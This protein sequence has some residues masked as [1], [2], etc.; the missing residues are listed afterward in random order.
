M[1]VWR[2]HPEV[3]K[4]L[5][6]KRTISWE[7]H[8]TFVALL[9]NSKKRFYWLARYRGEEC[10][11]V[12]LRIDPRDN[13]GEPGIFLAPEL[14]GSGIGTEIGFEAKHIYFEQ[15]GIDALHSVILKSNKPV[16]LTHEI[17]GYRIYA[18][19]DEADLVVTYLSRDRYEQ[20]P[21]DFRDYLKLLAAQRRKFSSKAA[22]S[23]DV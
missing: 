16:I 18:H 3:N 7:D 5:I 6:D 23:K 2:N 12:S 22:C 14:I 10:G 17:A 19:P 8:L 13:S 20:T 9:R 4:W 21:K 1:L 15:I 11:V